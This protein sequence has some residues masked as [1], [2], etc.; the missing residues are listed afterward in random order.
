M[1]KK[2]YKSKYS[3]RVYNTREEAIKD[4]RN[5]ISLKK[6][7]ISK[8]VVIPFLYNIENPNYKNVNKKNNTVTYFDDGWAPT[9][10]PGVANTSGAPSEWF[11]G[12]PISK[13]IVDNFAYDYFNHGDKVIKA[14]YDK[15]FGNE[16][17][18]TPSDTLSIGPRLYAAQNR[19]QR[20]TLGGGEIGRNAIL[21]AMAL[22]DTNNL[23]KTIANYTSPGDKNRIDRVINA[24]PNIYKYGGFVRRRLSNG[25][26]LSE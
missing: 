19:Y 26:K 18:R 3:G 20:G 13:S 9:I 11:S 16:K 21:D 10:G 24:Y 6:R 2:V 4:N 14:A 22:G 25:G 8:D 1:P 23:I 7:P 17:F 5:Y 12:K 15:R